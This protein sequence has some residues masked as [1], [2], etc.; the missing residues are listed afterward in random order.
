MNGIL[1][2]LQNFLVPLSQKINENKVLQ[3]LVVALRCY[4]L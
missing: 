2:N 4:Y 1:D 3:K